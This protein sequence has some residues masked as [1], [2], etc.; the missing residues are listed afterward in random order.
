M[1]EERVRFAAFAG[2]AGACLLF[3][4]DMLFYGQWGSGADALTGTM[5]EVRGAD[6]FRL[7]LGGLTSILGGLGYSLGVL[8]VWGRLS[9]TAPWLRG[10]V[11]AGFLLVA[12]I[13]TAT[14]AVW[15]AFALAAGTGEAAASAVGRYLDLHFLIGGIVGAPTSILLFAVVASGRSAW[16]R[17]FAVISPGALYLLFSTATWFPAPLGAAVV[18]GGFNL[19]FAAFYGASLL[20]RPARPKS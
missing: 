8:H 17:A 2:L 9:P 6:P 3:V 7:T 10:A 14:H 4:G 15:G 20:V 1:T 18:G 16:P 11:T 13:A 5:A 19:A 12:I